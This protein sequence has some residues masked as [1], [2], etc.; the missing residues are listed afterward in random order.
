MA[1][2]L[3][4]F[5]VLMDLARN[6]PEQLEN[7]RKSMSEEIIQDASPRIR[8]K[9]EGINFKVDM[10]RQRSKTPLQ[11]CIRVA[12]LMHDSF[13]QMREELDTLFQPAPAPYLANPKA[14]T[15]DVTDDD[16]SEHRSDRHRRSGH[17]SAHKGRP[18]NTNNIVPFARPSAHNQH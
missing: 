2:Q 5:D 11:S 12:A 15:D 8:H 14:L 7:I 17:N 16:H 4:S 3:P 1:S 9:L 18:L 6:N 13:S 10:E